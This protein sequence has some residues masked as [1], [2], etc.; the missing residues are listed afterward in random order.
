MPNPFQISDE[1]GRENLNLNSR[2]MASENFGQ[3][4]ATPIPDF[5]G[6]LTPAPKALQNISSYFR[7][8]IPNLVLYMFS[9]VR[10]GEQQP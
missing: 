7:L 4:N 2:S 9:R 1:S 8:D 10:W 3:Q 6:V 5:C